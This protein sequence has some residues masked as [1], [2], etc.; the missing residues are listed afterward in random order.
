MRSAEI[1]VARKRK[2]CNREEHHGDCGSDPGPL[3]E[4]QSIGAFDIDG[5]FNSAIAYSYIDGK[6]FCSDGV[7]STDGELERVL[8][9]N[10]SLHYLV[11]SDGVVR[12]RGPPKSVVVLP[13]SRIA[14]MA[15]PEYEGTVGVCEIFG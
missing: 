12:H 13:E 5:S 9:D 10:L 4:L 1:K 8:D 6:V 3:K 7:G 15:Q 11:G 2:K 14:F